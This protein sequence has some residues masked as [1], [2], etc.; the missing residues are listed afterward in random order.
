MTRLAA[1]FLLLS[2]AAAAS[3][4]AAGLKAESASFEPARDEAAQAGNPLWAIPLNALTATQERPLFSASRR[5]AAPPVQTAQ[6]V[7]EA[8]PV[9]GPAP[10]EGPSLTLIGTIVS[11]ETGIALLRDGESQ[12]VTRLR[13]GEATSGWLLQSVKSRSI[14]VEKGERSVTLALPEPLDASARPPAPNPPPTQQKRSKQ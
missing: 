6:P 3:G 12:S 11:Q 4:S 2:L 14:V 10:P 1:V 7:R 8:A 5:P 9:V 13:K